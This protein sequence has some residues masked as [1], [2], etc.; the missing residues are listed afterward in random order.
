[1]EK[2]RKDMNPEYC[3]DLSHI[4]ADK[5]AWE[6]AFAIAQERVKAIPALM[7]KLGG[8]IENLK[9]GL[10]AVYS[11]AEITER[12]YIYTMLN[13]SGDNG[14]AEAQEM[15]DKA[16]NNFLQQMTRNLPHMDLYNRYQKNNYH[17]RPFYIYP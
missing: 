11:A 3:W 1:M 7:G 9:M 15:E 6:Q 14:D 10:D 17:H 12:V 5:T 16:N 8:S 4:Y 13:S 2:N